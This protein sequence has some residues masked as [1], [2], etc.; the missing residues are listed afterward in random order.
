[1]RRLLKILLALG[2]PTLALAVGTVTTSLTQLGTS[3]NW[4]LQYSWTADAS[5]ATVPA[6]AAPQLVQSA[7]L[8]GY[9]VFQ[10]EIVAGSPAPTNNYT[11]T[12]TDGQGADILGAQASANQSSTGKVFYGVNAPAINGT[13]T[14]NVSGNAVNS[15][16]GTVYVYLGPQATARLFPTSLPPSGAAGGDLSGTYPNPTVAKVGGAAVPNST[17]IGGN[18]TNLVSATTPLLPAN[19]LSDVVS[20]LTSRTNLGAAGT[21]T[22]T[23]Q[24]VTATTNAGATCTT[25]T[26]AYVNTSIAQTGV[27]INTSFQVTVT[28]LAAALPV[29][30]G[31]IGVAT[32]T[33]LA[34]GN[35][36][37]AFTAA[38]AGTDYAAATNG[39]VGQFLTS[40]GAGGFSTA[41]GSSG[42]GNVA[43]VTSPTFVT[44][45]LGTPASGVMT[46]VTGLPVS[47]GI[48][49]LGSGVATLLAGASS[50]TGG[51]AG[52]VAPTFTSYIITPYSVSTG[53]IAAYVNA[54]GGTYVGYNAGGIVR[55]VADNSGTAAAL[56]LQAGNGVES[57]VLNTNN[58]FSTA[59]GASLT[60]GGTWTN[61]SDVNKKRN[62]TNVDGGKLLAALRDMRVTEWSY[63]TE[64][65]VRHLGP[66]A[67]DF[68]RAFG[69]GENDISITT[70]DESG[71]ALAAIK[72]L[73]ARLEKAENKLNRI[74]Q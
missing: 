16:Q 20:A 9:R 24:A 18:G 5:A 70:I 32:L 68:K 67:Q 1:M 49:G 28:H 38:V 19:N 3:Q 36:T 42:T 39:T 30:Q 66:T 47:T 41:V 45:A 11:V 73:A 69:L 13:L 29:N 40:D 56:H 2:T 58:S 21:Q 4:V 65:N 44:P 54:G 15:A 26:S 12:L 8:Q 35:G 53:A 33:G 25:L 22:C 62:F 37:G 63:R 60:A 17:Y 27:D 43:R 34:K 64:G 23:N 74:G 10:V 46:N 6:T 61:S 14:L 55:S 7:I 59:S 31:G 71:V 50:G 51:P 57:L 48:S 52:T 72:E